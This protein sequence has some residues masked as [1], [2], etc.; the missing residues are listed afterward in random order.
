MRRRYERMES[1]I[2][3]DHPPPECREGKTQVGG[4]G[5]PE[6]LW[7]HP[8]P[9][10]QVESIPWK[11]PWFLTYPGQRPIGRQ[12]SE[13]TKDDSCARELSGRAFDCSS[14][15]RWFNPGLALVVALT[16]ARLASNVKKW[17]HR[18]T[19][20]P[21]LCLWLLSTG[22]PS[23]F[24]NALKL[25]GRA[26]DC[27][28]NG[29]WFNPGLALVVALIIARLLSGR[30]F[31]CSSNGRWFN[32]GL[33]L[34]VALIIARLLSGRAFDCSSNGR[35]FNPGLALVVALIIARLN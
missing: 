7:V 22:D 35:W 19:L 5:Y 9:K 34:V 8:V 13:Q 18:M 31:D 24:S 23:R 15:G 16:I 29:R 32:P 10:D 21:L 26:F 20:S 14:N 12:S 30:A 25:S 17:L 33:A 11:V 6:T 27:S 28:S 1:Q 2:P 3:S 4:K